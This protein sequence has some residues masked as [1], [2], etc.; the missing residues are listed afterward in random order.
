MD[1]TTRFAVLASDPR[2]GE[3]RARCDR[4]GVI[5][6]RKGI[7]VTYVQAPL[8]TLGERDIADLAFGLEV[9]STRGPVVRAHGGGCPP[10]AQRLEPCGVPV[11][12][13]IEKPEA[14]A[15]D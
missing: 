12:A 10:T 1:G 3:V 6:P 14:G 9:R 5:A 11:I 13:K 15:I 4:A 7:F 8:P 2:T